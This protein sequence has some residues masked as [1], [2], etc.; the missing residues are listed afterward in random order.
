MAPELFG[1]VAAFGF[2]LSD[3]C[4]KRGLRDTS[5]STGLL[6]TLGTGLATL[7]PLVVKHGTG[8]SGIGVLLSFGVAGLLGPGLGRVANIRAVHVLGPSRSASIQGSTYPMI[9]FVTGVVFLHE[10]W[11]LA[12]FVGVIAI[13]CGIYVISRSMKTPPSAAL[14]GYEQRDVEV[15]T[16]VVPIKALLLPLAAGM[17][18]GASDVARK[19]GIELGGEPGT[20]AVAGLAA[21]LLLWTTFALSLPSFRRSL[22][23]GRSAGWFVISGCSAALS[24]LFIFQAFEGGGGISVVTPIAASSPLVVLVL[25]TVFLRNL[26][27]IRLS[28]VFSAVIVVVGVALLSLRL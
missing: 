15:K 2:G 25:S 12:K 11:T 18:Y 20:G 21:A 3:V 17:L 5:P 4:V 14:H 8:S 16:T 26:E 22:K 28:V 24:S 13:A 10:S 1:A 9:G 19:R 27:Q 23:V 6:I 7:A